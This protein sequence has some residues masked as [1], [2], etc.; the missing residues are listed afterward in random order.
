M[1][2]AITLHVP[3]CSSPLRIY[4]FADTHLQAAASGNPLIPPAWREDP[5]PVLPMD[6]E[7]LLRSHLQRAREGAADLILCGGDLCHFP[8]P[9]NNR[10]VRN[11]L[12][13][14]PV[15]VFRVPGNHDWFYP[16]QAGGA[17]LREQQLPVLMDIYGPHFSHWRQ[18]VHGIRFLGLD[19]STYHLSTQ[20]IRFLREELA[21]PIPTVLMMH[22]PLGSPRLREAVIAKHGKP[23]L[24]ADPE[25]EI[26]RILHKAP[27]L[28]ALLAAH[29]HLASTEEI[30]PGLPQI[31]PEAGYRHGYHW[32]NIRGAGIS[33]APGRARIN[34]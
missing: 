28:L 2:S 27:H 7:A 22:I 30:S 34:S 25:R 1:T 4:Y 20:Q 12:S 14:C 33:D 13:E 6:S 31:I 5:K 29:V 24:M 19:N 17:E 26:S 21:Q 10:L 3:A 15:P 16:D 32:I 9:E 23:L 18:D 8:S 11:L